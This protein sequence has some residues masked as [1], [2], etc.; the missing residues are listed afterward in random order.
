MSAELA[1]RAEKTLRRTGERLAGFA[2]RLARRHNAAYSRLVLLLKLVLPATAVGLML[3]VVLWPRLDGQKERIRTGKVV[4]TAE[5]LEN[6]KM[7]KPR[8]VGVDAQN[9][10]F[11]VTAKLAQQGAGSARIT[12][13]S[14]PKGDITLKDG[15][16]IALEAQHGA[17]DKQSETLELNGA[18]TLFHDRG[19]ELHTEKALVHFGPGLAEGNE[20]VR[21]QGPD[22]DLAGQGFR[23]ENKGARV[24]LTGQSRVVL[25]P[26]GGERGLV[27]PR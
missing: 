5:D 25:Y 17:Y 26:H 16:W 7:V 14:E 19:Y 21:G 27:A 13:L 6:M 24:L 11:M 18:V 9:Q 8:Y 10:P 22:V 1:Q 12:E 4:V 15:G 2:P 3:L 23:L 20:P